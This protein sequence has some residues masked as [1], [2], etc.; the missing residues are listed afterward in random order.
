MA[1]VKIKSALI[2]VFDKD[3]EVHIGDAPR[4]LVDDGQGFALNII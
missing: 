3:M 2:S 1:D 4:I